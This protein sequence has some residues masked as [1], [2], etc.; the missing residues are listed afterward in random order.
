MN[1]G[2]LVWGNF[3]KFRFL[4]FLKVLT[5]P[6]WS[7]CEN[8]LSPKFGKIAPFELKI[9]MWLFDGSSRLHVNFELIQVHLNFFGSEKTAPTGPFS[10]NL[11]LKCRGPVV[12]F[13]VRKISNLGHSVKIVFPG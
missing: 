3:S 8:R 11:S 7:I 13:W 12:K 10:P 1:P 4:R 5:H 6:K 2:T 9:C